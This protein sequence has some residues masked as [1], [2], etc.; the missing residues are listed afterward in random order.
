MKESK[1][2]RFHRAP[3]MDKVAP[4]RER[5][6]AKQ[7]WE[8]KS[9]QF[10]TC[11][12]YVFFFWHLEC[13]SRLNLLGGRSCS[14]PLA[15]SDPSTA[16]SCYYPVSPFVCLPLLRLTRLRVTAA[17]SALSAP[18]ARAPTWCLIVLEECFA[19]IIWM[20]SRYPWNGGGVTSGSRRC[21]DLPLKSKGKEVEGGQ[22]RL[23]ALANIFTPA[24]RLAH[25]T[26]R[27]WF[28]TS[29][30]ATT[31]FINKMLTRGIAGPPAI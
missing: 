25:C 1:C 11:F 16:S 14:K 20:P 21:S 10:L 17:N 18:P 3:D 15:A 9:K 24:P 19:L 22:K 2:H 5:H 7:K 30:R 4:S 29:V 13:H 26:V 6:E 27:L 12:F 31:I 8:E 28:S 23:Y